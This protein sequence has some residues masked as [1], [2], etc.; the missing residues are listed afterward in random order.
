M[1]AL[2]DEEEREG[3]EGASSSGLHLVDASVSRFAVD[4]DPGPSQLASHVLE[5]SMH[6][7]RPREPTFPVAPLLSSIPDSSQTE[8]E[9]FE[10]LFLEISHMMLCSNHRDDYIKMI[11]LHRMVGLKIENSGHF[12]YAIW[13]AAGVSRAIFGSEETELN[14][15]VESKMQSLVELK[16]LINVSRVDGGFTISVRDFPYE[17]KRKFAICI[18]HLKMQLK[19]E[20]PHTFAIRECGVCQ[21]KTT[22]DMCCDKRTHYLKSTA[23]QIQVDIQE[24]TKLIA[25]LENLGAVQVFQPSILVQDGKID[26]S[27]Y[28][29]YSRIMNDEESVQDDMEMSYSLEK[30]FSTFVNHPNAHL[31]P[32]PPS[33]ME[34]SPRWKKDQ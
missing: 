8:K 11:I 3:Y 13:T 33:W 19:Q 25:R 31:D 9:D 1:N 21:Q 20:M 6:Q 17:Y 27:Y 7:K 34:Q 12:S 30:E 22:K 23:A 16:F 15:Y 29:I 28:D 24:L 14:A 5:P 26:P 2:F 18:K 32:N 10:K 4:A